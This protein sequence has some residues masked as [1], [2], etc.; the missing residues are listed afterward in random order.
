MDSTLRLLES[1]HPLLHPPVLH[2]SP[3][4]GRS[5]AGG[6]SSSVWNITSCIWN[7]R[8]QTDAPSCFNRT[9]VL[10]HDLSEIRFG[11]Q[12]YDRN[13]LCISALTQE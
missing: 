9:A 3:N 10:T 13:G 12:K 5:L 2:F 8:V 11:P 7:G 6:N 1:Y 4:V